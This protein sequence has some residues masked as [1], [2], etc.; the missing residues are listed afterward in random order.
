MLG[1]DVTKPHKQLN[2]IIE[3]CLLPSEKYDKQI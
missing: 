3:Y 1:F 2:D